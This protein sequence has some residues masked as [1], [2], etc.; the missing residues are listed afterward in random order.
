[1]TKLTLL[2]SILFFSG[3]CFAECTTSRSLDGLTPEI[4]FVPG[5]QEAGSMH[6]P[7][8]TVK[9]QVPLKHG[10]L[11]L[12]SMEITEGEVARFYIPL[13]FKKVEDFAVTEIS[14]FKDTLKDF[15]LILSYSN[16][17]CYSAQQRMLLHNQSQQ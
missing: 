6:L 9:I 13:A 7:M 15:E 3:A 2:L 12:S 4:E 16:G 11:V 5:T 8:G 1:M 17:I 14:G 10:D